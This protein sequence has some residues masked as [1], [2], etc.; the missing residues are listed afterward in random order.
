M[1]MRV[2]KATVALV[3]IARSAGR[4][5]RITREKWGSESIKGYSGW[6]VEPAGT[7]MVS[8]KV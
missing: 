5:Y 6:E 7:G 8:G 1:A 3:Q 2:G 4:I